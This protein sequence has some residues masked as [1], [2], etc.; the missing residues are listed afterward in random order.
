MIGWRL[1]QEGFSEFTY[2]F[3]LTNELISVTPA[4]SVPIFP[5]L[6]EEGRGA[7]Y[8]V[9]LDLP[10][11]P[12][13]IQFKLSRLMRGRRA[14]E[15]QNREFYAPFYR[16]SFRAR[17]RSRQHEL[18]QTLEQQNSEGVY[19][20]AP[21]FHMLAQLNNYFE[22]RQVAVNS[23]RVRPSEVPL[24]D[25]RT[26]HWLSFQ[27]ASG[28]DVFLHSEEGEKVELDERPFPEV[29]T[30]QIKLVDR[31]TP[32]IEVLQSV[33]SWFHEMEMPQARIAS[34]EPADEGHSVL[35][36]LTEAA[37]LALGCTLYILQERERRA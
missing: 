12:L 37:Q 16:M 28:G 25:D 17:A 24:P 14:I 7:G 35:M 27:R 15:F 9:R 4:L 26:E 21:A 3:A 10:G 34:A 2:G 20:V 8:D 6:I 30:E 1:A 36:R 5:S 33:S 23:R 13:F 19:Y 29:L 31:R 32:L 22:R 11:K 18:L